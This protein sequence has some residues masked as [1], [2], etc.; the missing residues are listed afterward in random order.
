MIASGAELVPAEGARVV[1]GHS[2]A[3]RSVSEG[4]RARILDAVPANTSLAYGRQRSA[5]A[6]WCA[7]HG[8]AELPATPETLAEYV[9]HLADAGR[10]PATIEQAIA[11]IRTAHRSAGHREQPD[12]EGARM[13]L[14]GHRRQRAAGGRRARQ[15]TPV[16][17]DALRRM[18]DASDPVT[19]RGLRD[20]VALVLGL[21][22]M[23]RRSELVALDLD[24][25]TETPDG[26]EVLIRASKTDQDAHGV[27][28]AIP[29]GQH[30]DTDP[31]RLVRAWRA[32]LAEHGVTSGRLLR[33]VTRHGRLGA[34][35][36]GDAV[37]DLVRD[38][39]VR[40]E[41]PHADT[42]SAHSLRAGGATAAYRAGAPVSTIA[43][44]GR[45]SP[46]SPVVL[47]YVRAVDR[48]T[49]NALAGIGL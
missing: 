30:A 34:S 38:A 33:S 11:A 41:L 24:D 32:L 20:R 14:R 10:A 8:R 42:Y 13:V 2:D 48:W 1:V 22:L 29:P 26:L 31:V 25:V 37:A 28:V 9:A 44:H 45:W 16:T 23:G 12:T 15:A 49:D 27:V 39:A 6:A 17:I 3:D 43:A 47:S 40:A 36:S 18:V 19:V 7:E 46:G 21:A 5:F 35:L 4:T